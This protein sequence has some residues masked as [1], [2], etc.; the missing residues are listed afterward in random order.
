MGAPML[1]KRVSV[2]SS[3]I[4]AALLGLA[5]WRFPG[6]KISLSILCGDVIGLANFLLLSHAISALL[7]RDS[8]GKGRLVALFFL[9]LMALVAAFAIVLA[10]PID[11]IAFVVGLSAVIVAIIV[12]G[13]IPNGRTL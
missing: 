1:L 4:T 8:V 13:L 3:L 11:T 9:K 12:A 2:I 10:A 6:A 5:W 7:N